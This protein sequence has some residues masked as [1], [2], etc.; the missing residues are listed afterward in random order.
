M[1]QEAINTSHNS[2]FIEQLVDADQVTK[3]LNIGKTKWWEGV[4]AKTYPQPI[5]LG[6]RCTRWKKSE[7][8]QLLQ[9]GIIANGGSD[10]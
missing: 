3:A 8:D 10:D 4:K 7:I 9:S 2:V 6:K 1:S 5:R